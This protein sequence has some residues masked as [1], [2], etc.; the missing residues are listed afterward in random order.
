MYK[1]VMI[2]TLIVAATALGAT[3]AHGALQNAVQVKVNF[4]KAGASGSISL[5]LVNMDD[6]PLPEGKPASTRGLRNLLYNGGVVPQRVK[7]LIVQSS[8]IR[9]N[10]HALPYCK[11]RYNG[12]YKIPTRADG[13]SGA[14]NLTW[15]PG[16]KNPSA[17]KRNCPSKSVLGQGNFTATIGTPGVAYNPAMGTVLEGTIVA[18]NHA[19]R[20]GDTFAAVVRLDV[21]NPVPAT[22]YLYVGVNRRGVLRA[23]IPSRLEIPS[24]LDGALPPGEV[25]LTSMAIKLKAPKPP[26]KRRGRKA[27]KPIFTIKSFKSLNV[28]GQLVRE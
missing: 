26:K 25:S 12:Q 1:R 17:V 20:K 27:P 16:R 23:D 8:S 24:N 7:R 18:Y 28:Y 3:A 22:Q 10:R 14:E 9:Y 4:K 6:A 19:P 21:R 5:Q 15:V 2:C 11:L 13:I